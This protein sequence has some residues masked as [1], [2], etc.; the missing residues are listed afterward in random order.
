MT[1]KEVYEYPAIALMRYFDKLTPDQFDYCVHK[2][3][4]TAFRYFADKLT[5]EQKK[6]CEE[7]IRMEE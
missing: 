1:D 5:A 7:T 2:C 6:Y 3:P 4:S